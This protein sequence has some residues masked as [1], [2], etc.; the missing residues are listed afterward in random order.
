VVLPSGALV[1]V[2]YDEGKLSAIRSTDGGDSYAAPVAVGPSAFAPPGVLRSAPLPTATVD[3]AGTIYA[4]W[5]DCAPRSGCRAND[6]L[7]SHSTDGISWTKPRRVATGSGGDRLFPALAAD[8]TAPKR[9][10]VTY[11]AR[12]GTRLGIRIAVSDDGGDTWRRPVRLDAEPMDFSWLA[13][14]QGAMVGDYAAATL[15]GGRAVAI[16]SMAAAPAR[17]LN[18]GIFAASIAAG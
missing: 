12:T 13:D 9:I 17:R 15:A 1:V 2:Y 6:I 7:L 4:A 5:S 14:A 3:A 10:A 11:D 18:Q 8:E 16:F